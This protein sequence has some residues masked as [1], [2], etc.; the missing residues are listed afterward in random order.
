MNLFDLKDESL[1]AYY[2][3]I[4]RQVQADSRVGHRRMVGAAVKEYTD[5]LKDEMTRR[6]LTFTPIV[7]PP[8]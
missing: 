5:R 3:S 4:R 2:E 8:S 7:W 6:H 1:I